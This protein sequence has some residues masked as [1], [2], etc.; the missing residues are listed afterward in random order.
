ME[1]FNHTKIQ[2]KIVLL[3]L[4]LS[5]FVNNAAASIFEY[6]SFE[7]EEYGSFD[8]LNIYMNSQYGSSADEFN[9]RF[10]ISSTDGYTGLVDIDMSF[11]T[12][13]WT[14]SYGQSQDISYIDV[15]LIEGGQF[16]HHYDIASGTQSHELIYSGLELNTQY[17]LEMFVL[18]SATYLGSDFDY[19]VSELFVPYPLIY[20]VTKSVPGPT[21]ITI[22]VLSLLSFAIFRRRTTK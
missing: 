22:F 10:I 19:T 9:Y 8:S 1:I 12:D 5:L 11:W 20:T 15:A 13:L 16:G 14:E 3:L 2:K 21:P 18:A 4:S 6:G 17:R 7:V